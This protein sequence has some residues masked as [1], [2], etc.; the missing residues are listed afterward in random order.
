MQAWRDDVRQALRVLRT[1]PAF[2]LASLFMLALGIGANAAIFTLI[3]AVLLRPLPFADARQLVRITAD[4]PG[5]GA[6]DVG[7]GIP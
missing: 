5:R 4:L 2:A 3:D 6:R 7:V 1:S